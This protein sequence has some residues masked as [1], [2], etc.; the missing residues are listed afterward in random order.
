MSKVAYPSMKKLGYAD[1]LST[2]V[3]AAGGTLGILIPPSIILM[4][5]GFLTQTNIG[6]LFIAGEEQSPRSRFIGVSSSNP[7]GRELVELIR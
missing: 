6:H 2:G 4:I 1:Y 5:Y 7:V 3:I